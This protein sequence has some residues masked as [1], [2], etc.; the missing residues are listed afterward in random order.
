[1]FPKKFEIFKMID[2]SQ[3][4]IRLGHYGKMYKTNKLLTSLNL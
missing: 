1:M 2:K 3:D 4:K